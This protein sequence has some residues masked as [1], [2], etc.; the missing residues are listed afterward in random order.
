CLEGTRQMLLQDLCE[1][2]LDS[3]NNLAWIYGVA[4]TGKSAVAVTLAG[5]FRS[6]QNQI[7]LALTFHCVKGQETSNLSLLV[8]TICYQLAKVCPGYKEALI[9]L[10][11]E[12]QSLIGSGIPLHE[13]FNLLLNVSLFQELRE[14][15]IAIIIDGLDE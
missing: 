5:R 12:D 13:Q 2:A 14:Q 9:N 11:N 1:W 3:Q 10:F 6:M 15:K 7:T 4:G 8:P